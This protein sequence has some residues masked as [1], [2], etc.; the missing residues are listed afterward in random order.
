MVTNRPF[1]RSGCPW[2]PHGPG[3]PRRPPPSG[4]PPGPPRFTSRGTAIWTV[5]AV[6]VLLASY[7]PVFLVEATTATRVALLAVHTAGGV[8]IAAFRR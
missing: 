2:N 6:V 5:L 7:V 4:R 3:R 8:L 1:V